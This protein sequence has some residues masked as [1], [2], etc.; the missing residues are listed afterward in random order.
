MI[1]GR[2]LTICVICCKG[3]KNNAYLQESVDNLYICAFVEGLIDN[4]KN[5][6]DRLSE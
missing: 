3:T 4:N 2:R 1:V 6:K 5:K